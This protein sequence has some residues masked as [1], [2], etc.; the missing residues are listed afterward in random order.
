M[1]A[2]R[3]TRKEL[4]AHVQIDAWAHESVVKHRRECT[5]RICGGRQKI[6][7]IV[8]HPE[9]HPEISSRTAQDYVINKLHACAPLLAR[10]ATPGP[11]A[12]GP[13]V[14]WLP[15]EYEVYAARTDQEIAVL[16][17]REEISVE[18]EKEVPRE[19]LR[20]PFPEVMESFP[21]SRSEIARKNYVAGRTERNQREMSRKQPAKGLG[22]AIDALSAN[23]RGG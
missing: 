23:R 9:V 4:A 16:I 2:S 22:A 3:M 11:T 8:R 19:K 6:W 21:E 20:N 1:G 7:W 10:L 15:G 14:P 17:G 5:E 18:P 12:S 13:S